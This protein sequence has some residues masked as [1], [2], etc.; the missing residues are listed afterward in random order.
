[1]STVSDHRLPHLAGLMIL[2]ANSASPATATSRANHA[3]LSKHTDTNQ[4]RWR[5]GHA[6]VQQIDLLKR[7]TAVL[8]AEMFPT[9][10]GARI[11]KVF[12]IN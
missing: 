8:C 12:R 3:R 6:C 7:P 1:M 5:E 2:D 9:G 10:A 11:V 4:A